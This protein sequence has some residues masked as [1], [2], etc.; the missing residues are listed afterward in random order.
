MIYFPICPL[1]VPANRLDWIEKGES[2]NA[3]GLVLDLEDSIPTKEKSQTREALA[4]YLSSKKINK[5][6]L[7]RVNPLTSKEGQK[8]LSLLSLLGENFIG[9]LIPKIENKPELEALPESLEVVAL[10]ET[11]LAIKNLESIS[12]DVRIRGIALGGLDLSAELGSDMNWDSLIYSRSKIV[13]HAAI[14]GVY[15]IDSPF[16]QINN[17]EQLEEESQKAKSLGF[18]SKFAIHPNQIEVIK[19][20]FLPSDEEIEE[21]KKILKAYS[22][23]DGGVI[24]LDGKMVDEPIV[25]LMRKKLILAGL[26]PDN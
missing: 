10:I 26:D 11:P 5:P 15:S 12:S 22:N 3:D 8:D 18:N 2:S 17:M 1:F 7:I 19:R 23:S 25:K 9:L 6:F 4:D 13:L 20:N 21:A 16:V 14:N 24:E